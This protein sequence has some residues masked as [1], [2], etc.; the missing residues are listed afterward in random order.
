MR[1]QFFLLLAVSSGWLSALADTPLTYLL[2][3]A[4]AILTEELGPLFG[5]I[6]AS[7]GELQLERVFWAITIGGWIATSLL[8]VLGRWKWEVIRR[9]FPRARATGTLALRVVRRNQLK[10][11]F[12]VRFAFG[13]RIVLPMASGAARVPLYLYLPVSLLGSAVWSAIFTGLGFAMGGAAVQAVSHLGRAGKIVGALLLAVLIVLFLRWQRTRA[14][15][16]AARQAQGHRLRRLAM[17]TPWHN[18]RIDD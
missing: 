1:P 8:Y 5:G 13:L 18:P 6:A 10:A 14:E 15:R 7:E 9:R 3:G 11:S 16:K 4:S 17:K 12:F 2:L